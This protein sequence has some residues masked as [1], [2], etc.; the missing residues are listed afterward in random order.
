M[1]NIIKLEMHLT[2][3]DAHSAEFLELHSPF[4]WRCRKVIHLLEFPQWFSEK[5]GYIIH[6]VQIAITRTFTA[7][8]HY[9]LQQWNFSW[10]SQLIIANTFG[11]ITMHNH[12]EL[13]YC[14]LFTV[15][16]AQYRRW[17]RFCFF[18]RCL[19]DSTPETLGT[20]LCAPFFPIPQNFTRK[21]KKRLTRCAL[22]CVFGNTAK[23]AL[24]FTRKSLHEL[25][26]S[27]SGCLACFFLYFSFATT[28]RSRELPK[29]L[30][31]VNF[32]RQ[33]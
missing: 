10:I 25:V 11:W 1:L 33:S 4:L 9:S 6:L 27:S 12:L 31:P 23:K 19:L 20:S 5:S 3:W 32:S 30:S 13:K 22:V 18:F 17:W 14:F 29:C 16:L 26:D 21:N 7:S 28:P 2:P 15:L 8:C 24:Q